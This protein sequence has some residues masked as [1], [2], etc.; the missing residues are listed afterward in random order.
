[1]LIGNK[2]D[3]EA[4]RAVT[5]EDAQTFAELNNLTFTEVSASSGCNVKESFDALLNKVVENIRKYERTSVKNQ[6]FVLS[7]NTLDNYRK[8]LNSKLDKSVLDKKKKG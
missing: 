1:M 6:S 8:S 2:L 3:L 4:E 5:K 7:D